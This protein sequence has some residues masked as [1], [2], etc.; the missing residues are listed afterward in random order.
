MGL[1]I[2]LILAALLLLCL[3]DMPYGYYQFVRLAALA[4]FSFIAYNSYKQGRQTE[5]IIGASLALLFQPF[6]KI[7]L[8]RLVWNIADVAA[9]ALLIISAVI[10]YR[11][12]KKG[13]PA[14]ENQKTA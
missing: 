5:A 3:F 2:K 12:Q 4:V 1:K 11:S 6:V 7:V 8:T 10:E 9:A 14:R 13:T